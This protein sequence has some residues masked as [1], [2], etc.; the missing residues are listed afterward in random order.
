MA[1]DSLSEVELLNQT[2]ALV[3]DQML[4][5]RALNF[6]PEAFGA[7]VIGHIPGFA[8]RLPKTFSAS[9]ANGEWHEFLFAD[10]PIFVQA[11]QMAMRLA[12]Q[13]NRG[14]IEPVSGRSSLINLVS[15]S[16]NAGKE[17]ESIGPLAV[18]F[19]G[20]PAELYLPTR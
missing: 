1:S 17:L 9:A 8:T 12:H 20:I 18:A 4:A 10:E 14:F 11:V 5:R 7:M 13:G 3:G 6:V 2:V 19:V 16:L 15:K